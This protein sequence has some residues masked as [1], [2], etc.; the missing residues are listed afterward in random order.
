[1]D[2]LTGL[3]NA[4]RFMRRVSALGIVAAI[5]VFAVV[6]VWTAVDATRSQSRALADK[7]ETLGNLRSIISLRETLQKEIASARAS[8]DSSEFLTGASEAIIRG[9]LQSRFTQIAAS[10]GV[11]VLSV[12]NAAPL[13]QGNI[14]YAGLRADFSGTNEA[15]LSTLFDIE[16][17][18]PFLVIRNARVR[19]AASFQAN[20]KQLEPQIVVQVLFYGALSPDAPEQTASANGNRSQ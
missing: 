14:S 19:A 8:T 13:K 17:S 12:G 15:V 4:S 20:G 9:N 11:N 16:T 7:R 18:K 3:L 2:R 5:L 10:H 1:M 6:L